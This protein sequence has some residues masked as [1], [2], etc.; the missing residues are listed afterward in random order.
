MKQKL[1][2]LKESFAIFLW[3]ILF[4]I[5]D[6]EMINF[7]RSLICGNSS[8]SIYSDLLLLF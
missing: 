8:K 7:L 6:F 5:N 3:M 1:N 2:K 4:L